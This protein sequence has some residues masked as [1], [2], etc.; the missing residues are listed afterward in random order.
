M[1]VLMAPRARWWMAVATAFAFR[2]GFGLSSDFFFEDQTQVFLLGLRAYATGAWPYFGA[3]V[4]WTRSEIPGALQ[5]LLVGVP[6]R[7]IP[8]PEAPIVV[9][10]LLSMAA[11]I[12]FAWYL[13]AR[14]PRAPR[15][16]LWGFL[17]TTPWTI[18]FSTNII[19]TSYILP[20]S[21][22]FFIGFFEAVPA[23]RLNVMSMRIAH[24][25]MGASIAWLVQI[26]MSWPLLAPLAAMAWVSG[27]GAGARSMTANAAAFVAGALV[28]SVLLFPTWWRYGLTAGDGGTLRNLHLHFVN[29]WVL[30][31]TL[32]RFLSF[33]SLE[34]NRFIGTDG[35]KRVEFFGRHLWLAPMGALVWLAGTIQ[36]LWLLS[37]IFRRRDGSRAWMAIR[38]L[39]GGCVA[40]VFASYH[41]VIEPPQ[42]HAFYVLAP[43]AFVFAGYC[44]SFVDSPRARQVA[45]GLLVLN[46][47]FHAGLAWAQVPEKSLYKNRE[48]VATAIRLKQPEMFAHRRP[49]AIDGGPLSLQDPSRPYN[50]VQDIV[51]TKATYEVGFRGSTNW[52]VTLRNTNPRVAYRDLLYFTTYRARD[53]VVTERHEVIKDIFQ[54]G[55]E[56]TL[57]VNDGF[58]RDT[59]SAAAFRIAAAEALLPDGE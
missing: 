35:A 55:V 41:F 15:W 3:D 2:L 4:V 22:V 54:P 12:A 29:P 42:A 53:A 13:S 52:T 7:I 16:V 40:L 48:P 8:L 9:L 10:N 44:W 19:N 59:F 28:P 47:A 20:A 36:P 32:A 5:A 58:V 43:V 56:R 27:R 6:L 45:A 50:P 24:L 34:V 1:R 17:L 31:T 21:L 57:T 14:F 46:V 37:E 23:F 26:H 49:F 11:L 51:V 33:A 25:L 18:Q 38:W 39:V 30:V